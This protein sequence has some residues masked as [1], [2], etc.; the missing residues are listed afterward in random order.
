[1]S[2][3]FRMLGKYFC[4]LLTIFCVISEVISLFEVQVSSVSD[5]RVICLCSFSRLGKV[6]STTEEINFVHKKI[7]SDRLIVMNCDEE[8]H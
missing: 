2:N 5:V 3:I 1:M 4:Y 6:F 7:D 8:G